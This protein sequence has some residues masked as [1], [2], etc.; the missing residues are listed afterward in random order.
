MNMPLKW[1]QSKN[2]DSAIYADVGDGLGRYRISKTSSGRFELR[3]NSEI[4]KVL[5]NEDEAKERAEAGAYAL[6]LLKA[7]EEI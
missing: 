3:L 4:V 6:R 5:S 1:E 2:S 7:E